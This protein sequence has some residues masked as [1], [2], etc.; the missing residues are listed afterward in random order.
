MLTLCG[1]SILYQGLDLKQEGKLM[2]ESQRLVVTV[3]KFLEKVKAPGAGD[4]RRLAAFMLPLETQPKATVMRSPSSMAAPTIAKPTPS[5]SVPRQQ[6]RPQIYRHGSATM[7]ESDLLAQQEKLRRATLPN[8]N[9]RRQ[10]HIP[11]GRSSM[12]SARSES[13][14]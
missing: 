12:D 4:F 10:E 11:H 5:P 8:L 3:I 9:M 13:P 14:M 1:L 2:Q 6:I 7:S